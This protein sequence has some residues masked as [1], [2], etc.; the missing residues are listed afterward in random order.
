MLDVSGIK[1]E[2][3][4]QDG[5]PPV[6]MDEDKIREVFVNLLSNAI[7]ATSAGDKVFLRTQLAESKN[8]IILEIEDTGE[9]IPKEYLEHIF[10]PF[11][12]T[13]G[14]QGTGLGLSISYGI[15][16]NHKGTISVKS[17]AGVGT[18]FTIELFAYA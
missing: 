10:D 15:I 9:G 5:L 7:N 3:E 1:T 2:L 11:F 16:K 4:L 12:S 8:R 6:Y 14:T 18:I 13:K 17:K